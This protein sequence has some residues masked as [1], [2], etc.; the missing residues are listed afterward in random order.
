MPSDTQSVDAQKARRKQR[1]REAR[2]R[3]QGVMQGVVAML[4]PGDVVFDCGANVGEISAQLA[5]TGAD[6]HAF[7]PDPVAFEQ[8]TDRLGKQPN[9]HLN[10]VCVGTSDGT[11]NLVR[12]QDFAADPQARTTRSSIMAGGTGMNDAD[13]IPVPMI[14]LIARLKEAIAAHGTIAFLKLD[15]EGAELDL[16]EA[17]E[18]EALFNHIRLTVAET[19]Q[20][21][22]P[23]LRPRFKALRTRLAASYPPTT[24]FLD[25]I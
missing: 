17:M 3:A 16:L 15:I 25:W 20:G 9:V 10:P 18:A 19:H 11:V 1:R 14:D 21:K 8:L 13:A 7:E 5:A 2:I 4:R 6:V 22:F 24:V 23:A 12:A